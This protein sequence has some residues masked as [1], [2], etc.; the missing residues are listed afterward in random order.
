MRL[1]TPERAVRLITTPKKVKIMVGGRWSGK[2]ECAAGCMA[3]FA[4]D[5]HSI[6]SAREYL[7]S[8]SDSTHS[9]LSRKIK[10]LGVEDRFN[11]TDKKIESIRGGKIIQ[12]GLARNVGS[13]KSIDNI[14]YGW[15]E[16]GQFV[17]EESLEILIPSFRVP[18]SEIWVTMNRGSSKDAMS[19]EYLKRA[20]RDL[21][22]G[23]YYE[24]EDC[25]I[26]EINWR[27]NP[28]FSEEANRLRLSN[29]E[30][31]PTAKYE[32]VWEGAYADTVEN[33]II[34]PSWFDS[35]VDAH[36]KLGFEPVGREILA[37]DPSDT[38]DD[39][40]ICHR[41]GNV[42]LDVIATD[43]GDIVAATNWAAKKA[44]NI[45]VDVF[46]WDLG[47]MGTGLK[48]QIDMLLGGKTMT[49]FGFNGG[50]KVEFPD[51]L[52][53]RTEENVKGSKKNHECYTNRRAQK[54]SELMWRVIRTH[55]AVTKGVYHDPA[56]LISFSSECTDL[57]ILRSE[58]CSI[59]RVYNAGDKFQIMDKPMMKR[60]GIGSPN[61][62][63]TVM[64]S[65]SVI[66]VKKAIT[67]A[68]SAWD[69]LNSNRGPS[70]AK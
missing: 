62:A 30:R 38:G 23:G 43:S 25:I 17:S 9:L 29:K 56:T 24:D 39:K 19:V 22:R 8:I 69:Q 53:E 4:D 65:E 31:W 2:S 6:V 52:A 57:A 16:E 49:L 7:N 44:V 28:W 68:S 63:D 27:H 37:Y 21:K 47:G 33:A 58:L 3:K 10:E 42:I 60:I 51:A 32:H 67:G 48:G 64:M 12:K 70:Y 1:E 5:G 36:L 20:E 35:C 15:I 55:E 34:D 59:P 61:V 66:E 26:C 50:A 41:H 11:I 14:K 18:G 46:I 45:G 13:I 54:Y 40:A